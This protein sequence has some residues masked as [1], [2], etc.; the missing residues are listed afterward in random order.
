[1]PL[2]LSTQQLLAVLIGLLPMITGGAGATAAGLIRQDGLPPLVNSGISVVIV[3]FFAG[4]GVLLSGKLTNNYSAD[5][6]QAQAQYNLLIAGGLHLLTPYV[7]NLQS[8][9]LAILQ[10]KPVAPTPVAPSLEATRPRLSVVSG[11]YT[12]Q[13]TLQAPPTPTNDIT[14]G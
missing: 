6:V 5:F 4:L 2:T 3:G 11:G 9:F 14:G 12:S 8:N 7:Q 10:P 13:A 1:M